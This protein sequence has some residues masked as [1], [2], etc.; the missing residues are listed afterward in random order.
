MDA[1]DANLDDDDA[2]NSDDDAA[3]LDADDAANSDDD[4]AANLDD[5]DA[6]NLD[7]DDAANS[8]DDAANLDD[9]DANLDDDND[10]DGAS[11]DDAL[12][13]CYMLVEKGRNENRS[14]YGCLHQIN[15][16]IHYLP[17]ASSSFL[18]LLASS[19]DLEG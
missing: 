17:F 1:D 3:N 13:F 18:F 6:A 5:D 7:D 10:E 9:D 19:S 16:M 12:I 15:M 4:D 8:D 2:A 11:L 14:E